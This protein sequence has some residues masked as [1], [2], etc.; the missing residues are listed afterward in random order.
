MVESIVL[1]GQTGM[2]ALF[3][4]T[5]GVIVLITISMQSYVIQ[6]SVVL[7]FRAKYKKIENELTTLYREKSAAAADASAYTRA[8]GLEQSNPNGAS[9]YVQDAIKPYTEQIDYLNDVLNDLKDLK[10]NC[11][12]NDNYL[13]E[14]NKSLQESQH[15]KEIFNKSVL[16]GENPCHSGY[17]PF[18]GECLDES[19]FCVDTVN[20][21]Y[22]W[23]NDICMCNQGYAFSELQNKCVFVRPVCSNN[24]QW[25]ESKESC[26]PICGTKSYLTQ[27]DICKCESGY[28]WKYPNTDNFDCVKI[29]S[30]SDSIESEDESSDSRAKEPYN[31]DNDSPIESIEENNESVFSYND[32]RFKKINDFKIFAKKNRKG[33]VIMLW[34]P[35]D[36]EIAKK[37]DKY[38][39][40]I[41]DQEENEQPI[42]LHKKKLLLFKPKGEPIY[43]Y[44][45]QA[46]DK[47]ENLIGYSIFNILED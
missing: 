20:G 15:E 14:L 7:M 27:G 30:K 6:R 13:Y 38:S 26:V 11:E 22:D 40:T 39:V 35:N 29:K 33:I 41:L 36:K 45:I 32:L 25:V 5:A 19:L 10:R 18:N 43:L 23:A 17:V 2:G 34:K 1:R 8:I 37:V 12:E 24:F 28:T 21:H 9:K 47:N 42:I 31:E 16:S 44:M 3:V 4:M 46:F